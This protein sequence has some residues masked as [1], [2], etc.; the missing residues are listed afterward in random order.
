MD[1]TLLKVINIS[2][3]VIIICVLKISCQNLDDHNG[4]L[5]NFKIDQ[6]DIGDGGTDAEVEL[7]ESVTDPRFGGFTGTLIA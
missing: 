2:T 7:G 4:G 3:I 6:G 5:T 1:V